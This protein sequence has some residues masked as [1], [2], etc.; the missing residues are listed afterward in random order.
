MKFII[1][2]IGLLLFVF[3]ALIPASAT[4][5]SVSIGGHTFTADLPDGW[6]RPDY[7]AVKQEGYYLP[8]TSS[9]Y[10]PPDY[11]PDENV[12][13]KGSNVDP[14]VMF[15][16]YPNAP[17][18][19]DSYQAS[20]SLATLY[21]ITIPSDLKDAQLKQNIRVYGSANKIPD[22]QKAKD[23]NQ[24]LSIVTGKYIMG[25]TI[26]TEKDITFNDRPAHLIEAEDSAVSLAEIAIMLDENT[27]GF[28]EVNISRVPFIGGVAAS[29][30]AWDII[31]SITV[32]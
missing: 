6:I 11:Q 14:W 9:Y 21:V 28:I 23:I 25:M 10:Y 8:D 16:D 15:P 32:T 24:I 30:K 2:S 13:W 27:V 5:Q 20:G 7:V 22:D 19:D 4:A 12:D 26:N 29:G 18:G 1:A 31:N 17:K 3:I